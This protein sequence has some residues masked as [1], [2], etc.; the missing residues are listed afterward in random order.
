MEVV[1]WAG[2]MVTMLEAVAAGIVTVAGGRVTVSV[3]NCQS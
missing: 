2:V 3:R 1:L